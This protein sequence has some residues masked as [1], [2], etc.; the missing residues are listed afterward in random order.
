MPIS[1]TWGDS[2]KTLLLQVLQGHWEWP[3]FDAVMSKSNEMITSVDHTVDI[4][5]DIRES[6]PQVRGLGGGHMRRALDLMPDNLG[7]LIVVGRGHFMKILF[8]LVVTMH[9]KA[10]GRTFFVDSMEEGV[11]LLT[12]QC[13]KRVSVT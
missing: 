4:L 12:E 13:Q 10:R 9:E 7:V 3:D 5:G 11:A 6:L 2:E 8:A 1:V